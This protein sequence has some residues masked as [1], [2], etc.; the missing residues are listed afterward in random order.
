MVLEKTLESPLDSKEIKPVN[1]KG[2]QPQISL[3]GLMLKLQYFVHLWCKKPTHWKRPWCWERLKTGGE[4][5]DREWDGWMAS[6]TWWTWVWVNSRSWWW[7]GRPGVLQFMGSQ[8]VGH[9]W[10]TELNWTYVYTLIKETAYQTYAYTLMCI[11]NLCLYTYQ[12]NPK[13]IC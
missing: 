11:R 12:R 7:T 2:N 5:E 4:G 6:P 13:K 3:G 8:R 1:P 10:A 9:D